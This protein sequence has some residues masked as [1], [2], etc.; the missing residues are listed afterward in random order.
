[1]KKIVLSFILFILLYTWVYA[2]DVSIGTI[3]REPF[4]YIQNWEWT[5]FSIDLFREIAQRNNIQYQFQE[6]KEFSKMIDAT[7]SWAVDASVANISITLEREKILDFSQPIFDSGLNVLTLI[8]LPD[9]SFLS[10]VITDNILKVIIWIWVLLLILTHFFFILNVVRGNISIFSY[11]TEIF[12]IL[13]EVLDQIKNAYGLRILFSCILISS[14]VGVSYFGQR[15]AVAFASY[16]QGKAEVV[17]SAEYNNITPEDLRTLRVWVTMG[18]TSMRYLEKNN[19]AHTTYSLLDTMIG[20]VESWRIDVL[21]HDD[22]LLRYFAQNK[23]KD[24]FTIAWKT[25]KLEKFGIAFPEGSELR[26]KIDRSIL[27]ISEDGTYEKIY[28]KYFG[29]N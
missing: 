26:E 2:E 21:V 20:D 22:P 25:F 23:W 11:F 15:A 29:E 27:E 10:P 5:W 24:R 3:Q 8:G 6:F 18:S 4:S 1:M 17:A 12:A 14:I 28:E 16:E 7:S 19:I 9:Y 13:F